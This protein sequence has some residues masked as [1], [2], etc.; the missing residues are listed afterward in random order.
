MQI[1][2][3]DKEFFYMAMTSRER[4]LTAM[5]GGKADHVPISPDISVMVPDRLDGRPFYDI[6]LDGREHNGWTS[7]THAEV[8]VKAVKYF[9][10]DGFYMYGGL[11]QI[12]QE[13]TPDFVSEIFDIPEGKLVKRICRTPVG[14]M[15]EEEIYFTDEPPWRQLK[16]IKDL[17]KDFEKMKYYMGNGK[18]KWEKNYNDR[19]RIGELG[20][21]M[22]MIPVFQDWWFN[23]RQGGFEQCFMDFM[24]E[25]EFMQG[26][27][28]YWMQWALDN[29]RAMVV[30]KPDVIMLG[31]SS[32]SL[33]V[34]SPEIFRRYELPFIQKAAKICRA[35]GIP[36]HLH[37]CGKSWQLLEMV[38]EESELDSME[39]LEEASTGNVDMAEAKRR[40]GKKLCLKGNIN[41]TEFMLRAAPKE[42][43][44]KCKFLIDAA[45][46][47]GGFILSTGDQCGR[48]TPDENLF[49]MV[50]VAKTY[51]K[52]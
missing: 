49:K 43:E 52:Y 18:W 7:A 50:E 4:I 25:P 33:S 35:A 40:Y 34:S 21:Y 41:T 48:D 6:H 17:Q 27:H 28:E 30:A 26:V 13:D 12:R 38:A 5:R 8:Y 23:Y 37:V 29:V 1:R 42:I 32:A 20:I 44:E 15:T 24:L 10:M 16:P 51:G 11:K 3:I 22:G 47:D 36:S 9:Q 46:Q 45:A 31:G 39:P 2:Q 19:E 14:E